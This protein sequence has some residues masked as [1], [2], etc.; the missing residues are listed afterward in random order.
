MVFQSVHNFTV[1]V[2]DVKSHQFYFVALANAT[3]TCSYSLE[4]STV[5]K[6]N[7]KLANRIDAALWFF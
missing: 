4:K 2:R 1:H 6:K 7:E 5:K 3:I